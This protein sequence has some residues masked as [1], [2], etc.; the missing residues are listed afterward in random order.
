MNTK[1]NFK[2]IVYLL[3][4]A[5]ILFC[6]AEAMAQKKF[7]KNLGKALDKVDTVISDGTKSNESNSSSK[8]YKV[9][10]PSSYE[11]VDLGLSVLWATCNV[12]A[13]E[14]TG[15]GNYFSWGDVSPKDKY[16]GSN[17]QLNE[18]YIKE[19]QG[20]PSYDAATANWGGEWRMPSRSEWN[21]LIQ[22]CT[23]QFTTNDNGVSGYWFTSNIN[24]NKVFIPAAGYRD[25]TTKLNKANG[26]D[27]CF[28]WTST[29]G[30]KSTL[31][32]AFNNK[33]QTA[34][35]FNGYTVRPVMEKESPDG[36][37]FIENG[38]T[39]EAA[40]PEG[41]FMDGHRYVDMGLSVKWA[42]CNV[43][44]KK[45][46]NYGD[47]FAWGETTAKEKYNE[48]VLNRVCINDIQGNPSYDAARANWGGKWRMP[49]R[50]EWNE[51]NENCKWEFV[52][53]DGVGGYK[54]TSH[55]NGNSIFL[56]SAGK[57]DSLGGIKEIDEKSG[58]YYWSSTP[59]M[60]L[61]DIIAWAFN[62]KKNISTN[63][64]YGFAVR[65]VFELTEPQNIHTLTDDIKDNTNIPKESFIDGHKYVDL[66]LS[67]KWATCNVGA[68]KPSCNGDYFAWGEIT[69]SC[70]YNQDY[71]SAFG[72]DASDIAGNSSFDA[73]KSNWGGSWRMPTRNEWN[74]LKENCRWEFGLNEGTYGYWIT[75]KNGNKIFLPAAGMYD[76]KNLKELDSKSGCY[77]WTSAPSPT[78]EYLLG[79]DVLSWMF[80]DICKEKLRYYG[81]SIRP[82]TEE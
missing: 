17:T 43:G 72:K 14:A 59:I 40:V 10:K 50:S 35:R 69:T 23:P 16:T 75:G 77:Y 37:H 76:K 22:N 8:S 71:C 24:G 9:K 44:A 32:W 68:R 31:S 74:E 4:A 49:S 70:L 2:R 60:E 66:G 54:V 61:D 5:M 12:G 56:P 80:N 79:E 3:L 27:G 63:R 62:S 6:P 19:I 67:V 33:C 34:N 7:F 36:V 53:I 78:Y 52:T 57:F 55:I 15:F 65:P 45:P 73:A 48:S 13:T 46:S 18:K 26:T 11:Y 1:M 25:S 58:A 30:W 28:Y 82:V 21:E 29:P 20:N 47:L 39:N 51:L 41:M 64:F 42:T 81:A 38:S